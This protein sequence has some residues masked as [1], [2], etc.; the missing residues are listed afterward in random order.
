MKKILIVSAYLYQKASPRAL[1]TIELA[2]EFSRI[3]HDVTVISS[4]KERPNDIDFKEPFN[5]IEL[6]ELTWKNPYLGN[7][8][9]CLFLSAVLKRALLVTFEYPYIQF[10]WNVRHSLKEKNG[11]DLLI[12]IAHPHTVHWGIAS[13]YSKSLAKTWVADCGDP[14]ALLQNDSFK[15]WIHFHWIEKWFMRKCDY[16]SIPIES[17]RSSYFPE[18][19]GKIKIIPQGLTFPD[20]HHSK[21][22][23]QNQQITFAYTGDIYP[24]Q[25]YALHF[26]GQLKMINIP[27]KLIIYSSGLDLFK[28]TMDESV[29]RNCEFFEPIDRAEL[30]Q[31]LVHVDFLLFFPYKNSTQ[32]PFKLIDYTFLNKPILDYKAD[33]FSVEKLHQFIQRDYRHR[34]LGVNLEEHRMEI[35]AQ[36]FIDLVNKNL[37]P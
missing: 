14:Y 22:D 21:E 25:Q 6:G 4:T 19:N 36:S 26:F 33:Y 12:S 24:Y 20:L 31:K 34:Y 15:K 1:R 7:S 3:G 16:V 9:W 5:F 30:L 8:K 27:F 23:L 18:F 2:R 17:A 29:K 32:S 28:S 10:F 35:V 13:I 37:T 11:Y